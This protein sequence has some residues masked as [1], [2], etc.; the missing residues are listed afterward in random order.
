LKTNN[1]RALLLISSVAD[2]SLHEVICIAKW[3]MSK[4]LFISKIWYKSMTIIFVNSFSLI[5]SLPAHLSVICSHGFCRNYPCSR[6]CFRPCILVLFSSSSSS[7][8]NTPF[9][10]QL[11]HF[12]IKI[13]NG[14]IFK[15]TVFKRSMFAHQNIIHGSEG[16]H[17]SW[18][19]GL[20]KFVL[21]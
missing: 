11:W 19:Q 16:T 2:Y 21:L 13:L 20:L 5:F 6:M 17:M 1:N 4:L 10:K 14:H 9:I 8:L 7:L 15:V 3:K 12:D 18:V